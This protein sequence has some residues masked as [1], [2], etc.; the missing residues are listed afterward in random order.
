MRILHTMLRVGDLPRSI[1]FYTRVLDM[2]VLRRFES[3]EDNYTLVFLG[4]AAESDSC[5]IELTYN[6]GI[7]EYDI[8]NAFGHI[9]IAVDNCARACEQVKQKQGKVIRE[10]GL[11]PGSTE[12]IAFIEDPDGYQ[13]ELIE[14][15]H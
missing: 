2:K 12:I 6:E 13:I 7:S 5:V 10:A 3:P 1:D 9:A 11:L 14:A 15:G 8:G 4:Y